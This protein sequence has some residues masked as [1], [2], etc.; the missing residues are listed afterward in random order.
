MSHLSTDEFVDL[1]D[2]VLPAPRGEHLRTCLQCRTEAEGLTGVL[3]RA[4][5]TRDVPEPSPL[6]WGHLAS[7]IR[8]AV[9]AS[10]ARTW[11]ELVWWPGSAWA[12]GVASMVLV[13]L[14][15]QSSFRRSAEPEFSHAPFE[16]AA[17]RLTRG[18]PEPADDLESDQAWAVVRTVADEA[19][20]NAA[21]DA[22]IAAR[23]DAAERM[24]LE[25]SSHEKSELAQLLASELK[26]SGAGPR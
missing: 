1:L 3:V 21:D 15:S 26:R 24:T 2:D 10:V 25:L 18:T 13:L 16:S 9:A 5:E 12:A 11:R 20:D 8:E 6:F 19:G 4:T 22:G 23:P 14:V 7:R 17:S